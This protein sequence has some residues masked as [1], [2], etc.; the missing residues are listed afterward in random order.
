MTGSATSGIPE[1]W[2]QVARKDWDRI[3]RSLRDGDAE[4][5]G[6]FLQQSLEKYLKAFLVQRGWHLR[7]IHVLHELLSEAVKHQAALES[8][9]PLCERVSGYYV[10]DRYPPLAPSGITCDEVGQDRE[11]ARILVLRMFPEEQLA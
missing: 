5:A 6:Y 1:E 2:K 10:I 7:K 3:Q 4:A 8:F 11:R 9:R